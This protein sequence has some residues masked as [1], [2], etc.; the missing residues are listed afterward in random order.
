M[1]RWLVPLVIAFAVPAAADPLADAAQRGDVAALRARLPDPA[2]R[3][4][5]GAAYA[6]RHDLPRAALYLDGCDALDL[7]EP[8]AGVVARQARA[9]RRALDD[10]A[11]SQLVIS[12]TPPGLVA[13]C[14]ALPGEQLATPATVWVRAGTYHV[15][16]ARDAAALAGAGAAVR[17]VKLPARSRG[18][19]VIDL[20]APPPAAPRTGHVDLTEEGAADPGVTGPPPPVKHG[21]MLPRRYI[22]GN[23]V[24]G[25]PIAD[26]LATTR[27]APPPPHPAALRAGVRLGAS[28]ASHA[29]GSRLGPSLAA[30]LHVVAPWQDAAATHPWGLI[31]RLDAS[32]RGGADVPIDAVGTSLGVDKV[33][34]APSAAWLAVGVALRGEAR[35]GGMTTDRFG[36]GAAATLE[37]ALRRLPIT[38]GAR[39]EQDVTELAP[40]MRE[41]A[42]IVELGGELRAYGSR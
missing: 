36:L 4:A 22:D 34:A 32:E 37:L 13:E 14:D 21:S 39:F 8:L 6:K 15:R 42:I 33:I 35:L 24:G 27:E 1:K 2:A 38:V 40:G 9:V 19:V 7:P 30:E 20:G 16:V 31:A 10:S 18:A 41:H 3:C 29:G 17:V 26:P 25:P 12:T 23:T 5:L 28:A 11:L